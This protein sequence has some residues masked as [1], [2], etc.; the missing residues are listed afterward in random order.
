MTT[1]AKTGITAAALCAA[2]AA[3][4]LAFLTDW[5]GRRPAR[6]AIPLVD[7]NFLD[8]STTRR[9]YA[10]LVRAGADLSDFDCYVCHEKNK[11]P[12]LR[13][14]TNQ[15]IIVAAE[16]SDIV[17]GHG[18]H[19]RNNNCFNCHNET[20][21]VLL[22]PRD[23]RELTF[24]DSTQLCGSCH[25]PTYRDWLAGAHGRISGYWDRGSAP[26]LT[27]EI[28]DLEKLVD[29]WRHQ[30]DPVSAF[31]WQ[32]LLNRDQSLLTGYQPPART[33]ELRQIKD[34]QAVQD[35]VVQA[36]NTIIGE[37]SIY[38]PE[39]F[40]GIALSP[41]TASL[42]QQNQKDANLIR[43]NRLLLQ[44]AYPLELTRNQRKDC[45]N[46]HNPHSPPFPSRKP[47]PGPHPLRD[48]GPGAG[49]Q[50]ARN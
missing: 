49:S 5:G 32:K 8:T 29:R 35:I 28:R 6:P 17:M 50:T 13:L 31:V 47:A 1:N 2:F 34:S 16:H 36:L 18:K 27:N 42:M 45:V 46:C 21:L 14:N 41:E 48:I 19:G 26:F 33:E 37:P 43:L 20:N 23:G 25:G 4:A 44:D 10:D 39:R 9:S 7:T 22:Q 11:P 12:P 15:N 24:A 38:Q 40:K 30:S 3:L